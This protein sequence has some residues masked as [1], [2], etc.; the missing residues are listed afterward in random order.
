MW[1]RV[2]VVIATKCAVRIWVVEGPENILPI[3][4]HV[5]GESK[6]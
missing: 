2:S 4:T 5:L 3:V 6:F 1:L